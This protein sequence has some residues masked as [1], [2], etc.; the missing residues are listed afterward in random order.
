M[1]LAKVS[2]RGQS[3]LPADVRRK[4]GIEP[5]SHVDVVV[6]E[7]AIIIRPVKSIEQLEGILHEHLKGRERLSSDEERRRMEQ[8][9]ARQA[10]E[11]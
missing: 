10:S 5:H 6:S 8:A 7:G 2:S 11:G 3:T 1:R 4:L 9:V